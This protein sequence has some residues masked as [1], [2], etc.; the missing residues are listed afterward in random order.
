MGAVEDSPRMR[1]KV[2]HISRVSTRVHSV[3]N[4]DVNA[5]VN[6]G[7]KT[8]SN[9]VKTLLTSVSTSVFALLTYALLSFSLFTTGAVLFGIAQANDSDHVVVTKKEQTLKAVVED[10]LRSSRFADPIADYNGIDSAATVLPLGTTVRI[11]RPY[12]EVLNF[13]QIA[14]VK[15][16]VTLAKAVS[17]VNPPDTGDMVHSGDIIRTGESGFVSISFHSG[18]QFSLQPNSIVQVSD[19][20]C[21]KASEKCLIE[22]EASKGTLTSEVTPKTE[23]EPVEFSVTT[24]FLSAAVRGTVLYIDVDDKV[25]RVGVTRGLVVAESAGAQVDLPGGTGMEATES[26]PPVE[27]ELLPAPVITGIDGRDDRDP[28]FSP[29]DLFDWQ[30]IDGALSYQ[31]KF[32]N[33]SQLTEIAMLGE[34]S[35]S[36]YSAEL[37]AGDYFLSVAAIDESDFVGIPLIVPVRFADITD[38]GQPE[39]AIE[40]R[41][42]TV[43]LQLIG[44]YANYTGPVELQIATSIDAAPERIELIDDLSQPFNLEL[45][46]DQ[47]WVFRVRKIFGPYAVS[48]YSNHY[49]LPAR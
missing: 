9:R 29:E 25:N 23:G 36:E 28:V 37:T 38:D 11:P 39:L 15:G 34:A 6:P 47:A 45:S 17:V 18:A 24:P 42:D 1:A 20:Q 33:D 16:D 13:G 3:V 4:A 35:S 44:D 2:L 32:A 40:R 10:V 27:V 48:A 41:V 30:S 19:V 12:I 31:V 7:M 21:L 8:E 43:T 14:F 26:S 22:L 46:Q 49:Q 5:D